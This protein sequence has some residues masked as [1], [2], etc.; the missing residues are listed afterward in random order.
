MTTPLHPLA[1]LAP[2]Y[3]RSIAAYQPGK[4]ISDVARELP[5]ELVK[6]MGYSRGAYALGYYGDVQDPIEA[7]HGK[8]EI[9]PTFTAAL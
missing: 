4:P 2:E 5:I 7:L 8:S 6:L 9:A 1:D 3:I